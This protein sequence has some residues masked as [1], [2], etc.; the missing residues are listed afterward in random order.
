MQI[1]RRFLLA[2]PRLFAQLI[3]ALFGQI[4]RLPLRLG[5]DLFRLIR[6]G[7]GNVAA[8]LRGLIT[9]RLRRRTAGLL[10][11]RSSSKSDFA[12]LPATI[13][14]KRGKEIP[15]STFGAKI[16]LRPLIILGCGPA[17]RR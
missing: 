15:F 7:S 17:K 9:H 1:S 16:D 6:R 5:R 8:G 13:P 3:S 12:R 2:F 10:A 11:H 14:G 4:P